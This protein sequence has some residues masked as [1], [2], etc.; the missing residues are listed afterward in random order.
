MP[1]T[2]RLVR[3]Q[4]W[5][6]RARLALARR[7]QL[8][9]VLGNSAWLLLDKAVR[10]LLSLTV[11]ALLA[12]HLGPEQFGVFSYAV[13]FVM[14]WLGLANLGADGI[15]VRDL[16]R[17]P[18]A[19]PV[20][21]G[22]ALLAR[23]LAGGLCWLAAVATLF[24]MRP[25][26]G[27]TLVLVAILGAG[28]VLQG[29]ETVDVWFQ[30]QSQNRRTVRAKLLVYVLTN[31][32]RLAMIAANAPLWCFALAN[33]LDALLLALLLTQAY[34]RFPAQQAWN[35]SIR[36]ARALVAESWPFMLSG[37]AVL[38]YMRIDQIMIRELLDTRALGQYAAA[39]ALSQVWNV[40]PVTLCA[41]LAP[42]LARRREQ[43]EQAYLNAL[44]RVFRA[45][46]A[47]GL[48]AVLVTVALADVL[49]GWLYGAAYAPA[50]PAL[51]VH[52]AS[53][54]FIFLGVAQGLW[55]VNEGMGRV[56]LYRTALGAVVS[57]VGNWLLIPV[58]GLVGAALSTTAAMAVAGVLSNA[59][60]AP[61]IL[62]LQWL[63]CL[64]WISAQ[65]ALSDRNLQA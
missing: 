1:L 65:Q 44:F 58:W 45:F 61:T 31:A 11:G 60:W 6:D 19:A 9:A 25:D 36:H 34:R 47:L 15:L 51:R 46:A 56:T 62:R 29:A 10:L 18:G 4:V 20:L 63:A 53:N 2:S 49:V 39:T 12:R 23:L 13:T 55:L 32:L 41:A 42:F 8:Q 38:V 5:S 35:A 17:S 52:V 43:G 3:W 7:P 48:L 64:P 50:V 37:L 59:F 40:I 57:V 27:H 21:L 26:D 14:F 16:A 30:S 28:L 22:S 33:V 54:F 24:V